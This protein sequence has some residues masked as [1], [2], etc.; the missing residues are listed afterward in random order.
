MKSTQSQIKMGKLLNLK[1]CALGIGTLISLNS[2]IATL[3][4]LDLKFP[5]KNFKFI[6]P[7]AWFLP[8][9]VFQLL[10]IWIG[11]K[12][13]F[14]L[15]VVS[16]YVVACL[17]FL[18]IPIIVSKI[19][20][21]AGFG[22][23]IGCMVVLASFVSIAEAAIFGLTGMLA[24]EY[25]NSFVVGTGVSGLIISSLRIVC[26]A[27]F[28]NDED[29]LMRST[30][31]Y[32]TISGLLLLGCIYIQLNIMK[33]PEVIYTLTKHSTDPSSRL[34]PAEINI[35]HSIYN[36]VSISDI[37]KLMWEDVFLVWLVMCSTRALFP[38]LALSTHD[39]HMPYAWFATV[40]VI[41]YNL[42]NFI[43]KYTPK[44]IIISHSNIWV[45]SFFRL[46]FG[47]TFY[48]IAC[49]MSPQWLFGS[50]WFKLLNMFLFSLSDGYCS[51]VILIQSASKL[52]E[53]MRERAGYV[54]I[55]TMMIGIFN[56]ALLGLAFQNTGSSYK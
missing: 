20:G 56:G 14:N 11:N 42:G 2:I 10:T 12:L 39:E 43:G 40:M 17:F 30:T 49:N 45:L 23:M 3:D 37:L 33:T 16:C 5:E 18:S 36:S 27:S 4:W 38:G 22:V 32:Y 9:V 26:L 29:G 50:L 1:F 51:T 53:R 28:N 6:F 34:I 25:V 44:Y 55:T 41:I 19:G 31:V 8:F 47:V 46:I 13:S 21:E 54:I 52:P 7:I 15:R 24:K 35:K 48:M